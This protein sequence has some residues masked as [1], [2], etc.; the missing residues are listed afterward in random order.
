SGR[1]LRPA[2]GDLLEVELDEPR[3]VVAVAALRHLEDLGAEVAGELA[4]GAPGL[5][6]D[7]GLE[8]SEV[9]PAGARSLAVRV[10]GPAV[11]I[12]GDR[13]ALRGELGLGVGAG[14]APLALSLA[15]GR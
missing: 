5:G 10:E 1:G 11:R 2:G 8:R 12:A 6:A 3:V 14:V 9:G 7:G 13:H 15:R 4:P